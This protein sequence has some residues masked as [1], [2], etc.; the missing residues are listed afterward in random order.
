MRT[1]IANLPLHYGRAP[2]WLFSRM[3]LLSRQII[4]FIIGELGPQA[5]LRK[6]SDPFWFQALGAVLGFDWHSSGLTTTVCGALKAGLKGVEEEVGFFVVGGKGAASR[7]TPSEIIGWGEKLSFDPQGLV[8]ASR[9]AA[10]V[11]SAGLQD[12][13][14]IYHHTFFFTSRGEW[15]VVQQGMDPTVR[16]ARRYHWLSEGVRDFCCEPHQAICSE[17]VGW[18]LNMVSHKSG[19][20][21]EVVTSLAGERP[22]KLLGELKFLQRLDLPTRHKILVGDINPQRLKG[23]FLSTYER[24][25]RGFEDLLGRKGVGPKTI[26]ALSLISELIYGVAPSFNDPARFSFAHGGKDGHPYPV[27]RSIYDESIS[28]LEEALQK[29]KLGPALK[30][31][32]LRRLVGFWEQ[33]DGEV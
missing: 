21:R 29:A 8:Y 12:G 6:I 19:E 33:V 15:A 10:K 4:L 31:D 3:E 16:M 25:P 1:G 28:I 18:A 30:R 13:Y 2:R 23:I 20:A 27:D 5:L 26:R 24:K 32:A 17:R 11:D 22:E 7:Q 9:M 14:Q